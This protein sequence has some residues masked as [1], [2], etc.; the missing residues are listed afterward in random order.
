MTCKLHS[1]QKC[2][3]RYVYHHI[4]PQGLTES[5]HF[6]RNC[7]VFYQ[8]LS[9]LGKTEAFRLCCNWESKS[10]KSHMETLSPWDH[11]RGTDWQTA[12][13]VA[14]STESSPYQPTPKV[15]AQKNTSSL[16][17]YPV[18]YLCPTQKNKKNPRNTSKFC[19]FVTCEQY[20]HDWLWWRCRQSKGGWRSW[21][22][23]QDEEET[24]CAIVRVAISKAMDQHF[25]IAEYYKSI[26]RNQPIW[27]DP[28][29]A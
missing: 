18:V 28:S 29:C 15:R 2:E 25:K 14:T 22:S 26:G 12:L 24:M 8:V 9:I 19:R 6:L 4:S 1:S 21:S 13:I 23:L 10:F 3:T 17:T 5:F 7:F 16:E 20:V 11:H 27:S